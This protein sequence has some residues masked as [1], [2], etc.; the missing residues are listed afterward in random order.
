MAPDKGYGAGNGVVPQIDRSIQ[1]ENDAGFACFRHVASRRRLN[2][3]NKVWDKHAGKTRKF[4]AP[5][6]AVLTLAAWR[7][8]L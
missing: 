6:A 4:L 2:C 3:K 8:Y 5:G 1:I 7:C